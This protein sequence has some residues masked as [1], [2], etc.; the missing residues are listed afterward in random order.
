MT[1][2]SG[3]VNLRG[4]RLAVGD[5]QRLLGAER[6]LLAA[7]R[8]VARARQHVQDLRRSGWLLRGT[9]APGSASRMPT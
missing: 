2:F 6:D 7:D 4:V 1:V 8:D 9:S 5:V 3:P